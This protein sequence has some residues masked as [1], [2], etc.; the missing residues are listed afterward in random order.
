[1]KVIAVSN[2]N[3]EIISDFFVCSTSNKAMSE[4]IAEA[5]NCF[6]G[7]NSEYFYKSVSDDHILYK[8]EP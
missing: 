1:M 3:D 8:F 2:F 4:Q 5:L 7:K 6:H